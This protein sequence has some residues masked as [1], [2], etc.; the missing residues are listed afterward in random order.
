MSGGVFHWGA[1]SGSFVGAE[2]ELV[3]VVVACIGLGASS[4]GVRVVA[5]FDS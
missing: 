1:A 5:S 3:A 2:E 4:R